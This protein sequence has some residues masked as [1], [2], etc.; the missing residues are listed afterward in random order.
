MLRSN[1]QDISWFD[2][3]FTRRFILF[4]FTL[5]QFN[6]I[7]GHFPQFL[8]I[9]IWYKELADKD[10]VNTELIWLMTEELYLSSTFKCH[11]YILRS[12]AKLLSEHS[13]ELSRLLVN[14]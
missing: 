3:L 7:S 10:S 4:S 13:T 2:T 9:S 6:S 1:K 5:V 12:F 11:S 8:Q 14:L